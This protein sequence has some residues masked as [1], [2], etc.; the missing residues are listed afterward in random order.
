MTPIQKLNS[1]FINKMK[2]EREFANF[3]FLF[4]DTLNE[5]IKE[6][7]KSDEFEKEVINKRIFLGCR[8]YFILSIIKYLG[9]LEQEVNDRVN[10]VGQNDLKSE[11]IFSNIQNL[12]KLLE[13]IELIFKEY[14]KINIEKSLERFNHF[15]HYSGIKNKEPLDIRTSDDI[16]EEIVSI[17]NEIPTVPKNV[18]IKFYDFEY[19]D[20]YIGFLIET[21]KVITNSIQ[22]IISESNQILNDKYDIL[23]KQPFLI[24]R[25]K[26]TS[27]EEQKKELKIVETHEYILDIK[28]N[29]IETQ[30]LLNQGEQPPPSETKSESLHEIITHKK[31][32]DI[33]N[34]IKIRYKNIKGKRLK[35]LLKALQDLEL[36]PKD[37][38]GKKFHNCCKDEFNWN[39][40]SYNAMNCYHY[41][42]EIDENEIRSMKEYLETLIKTK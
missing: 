14:P 28:V 19:S 13:R 18:L 32:V 7:K 30:P 41:N 3:G 25:E 24:S 22:S 5:E 27:N 35:L 2:F 33:V 34:G 20:V 8:N 9:E 37:R 17:V 6:L 23:E 31:S 1:F 36:L 4:N 12:I 10:V 39:I 29:V 16:I 40:G 26:H 15:M 42:E 11:F 38:I 21:S